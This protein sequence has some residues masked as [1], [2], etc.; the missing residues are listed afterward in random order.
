MSDTSIISLET[1]ITRG[2]LTLS[3]I[4]LRKPKAGALRG[5]N[6]TDLLQMDVTALTKVIPRISDP[7]LTEADV[8]NLDP[9]DLT[10]IGMAV[11]GFLL[12]RVVLEKPDPAYPIQ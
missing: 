5:T 2:E 4:T 12:P 1:P 7:V 9:A 3:T 11:S 6:L 8:T 10:Q